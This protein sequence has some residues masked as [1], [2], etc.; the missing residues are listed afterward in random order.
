MPADFPG[1]LSCG[2][3]SQGV[4]LDSDLV[5][6]YINLPTGPMSHTLYSKLRSYS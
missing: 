5:T 3:T 4:V 2:E 1:A 6:I